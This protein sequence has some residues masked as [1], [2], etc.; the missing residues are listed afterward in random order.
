MTQSFKA[1]LVERDENKRQ[2]VSVVDMTPAD[3]MDGNVEIAVAAT[4]INYK[5]GL[6]LTGKAPIVRRFPLVPGIDL[7]GTVISSSHADWKVGD[8]VI[9]NGWG[10]GESHYGAFAERARVDGDWLVALPNGFSMRDAMAVGTAGFT[11][12]RCVMRLEELGMTPE[13]GPVVV[14]GASGGVGSVA[15]AIL[16]KLGWHVVAVTGRREEDEFLKGLGA[17]EVIDRAELASAPK[18]LE[19]QRWAAGVDAVGGVTLAH[20]LAS[21]KHGG[22]V[23]CCGNASGMDL[24]TSVAPFIL[25]AVSLLGVDAS[26][27]SRAERQRTWARIA[28][29]LDPGKLAAITKDIGFAD[30]IEAGREITEGKVRGRLVVAMP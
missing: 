11:A 12:M 7:A 4:T 30:I 26:R 16:A 23:A 19:A 22:A 6:A 2:S 10:I 24:P 28:A 5:D 3:L 17:A 25:R 1:I 27:V 8:K 9:L 15:I 18:P 29:D 13:R 21:I 14:T 20:M